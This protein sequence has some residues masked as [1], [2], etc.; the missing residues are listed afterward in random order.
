[1]GWVDWCVALMYNTFQTDLGAVCKQDQADWGAVAK[2][3][4]CFGCVRRKGCESVEVKHCA[5]ARC[6]ANVD[7]CHV[8]VRVPQ[9]FARAGP[10]I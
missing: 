7:H 5:K 6:T 9:R 1:V 4:G 2:K 8:H 3:E 10:Q